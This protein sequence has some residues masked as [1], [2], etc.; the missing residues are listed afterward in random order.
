MFL[1]KT[2]VLVKM[3]KIIEG[4]SLIAITDH[5]KLTQ[6]LKFDKRI[7]IKIITFFQDIIIQCGTKGNPVLLWILLLQNS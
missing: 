7:L 5:K 3:L 6:I 2:N 1:Q 4:E